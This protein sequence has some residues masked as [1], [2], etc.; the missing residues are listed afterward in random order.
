MEALY[1]TKKIRFRDC[2][3]GG[4]DK[5][6]DRDS[7]SRSS[8]ANV[9][10]EKR[11]EFCRGVTFYPLLV[12]YIYQGIILITFSHKYRTKYIPPRKNEVQDRI[13]QDAIHLIGNAIAT[14]V[15][16]Y[17]CL[18]SQGYLDVRLQ[19]QLLW[20]TKQDSLPSQVN[21]ITLQVLHHITI[22]E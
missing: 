16:K 6:S 13:V 18:T 3:C 10:W 21:A 5:I 9:H 17:L 4:S 14:L 8:T 20:Y 1:T 15:A 2:F 11:D 19:F 12:L 7:N 22:I